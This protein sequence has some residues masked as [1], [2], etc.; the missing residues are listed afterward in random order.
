MKKE[1]T[2]DY[3]LENRGCYATNQVE[4]LSFITK[5]IISIDDMLNSEMPLKDKYWWVIKKCDLTIRQKQDL[6]ILCAEIVLI[7]YEEKYSDNKAPRLAIEAAK[8]YLAGTISIEE[9]REKRANAANA[10]D[11]A[12]AADA[13]AYA[14]Y[15]AANAAYAAY[16]AA[17]A[18]AAANAARKKYSGWLISTIEKARRT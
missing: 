2:P 7:I 17:Y 14:A 3:I 11:A 16:S 15:A 18:N 13:A 8:D 6:A 1:F 9:L 5:P 12:Y 4:N 10:A